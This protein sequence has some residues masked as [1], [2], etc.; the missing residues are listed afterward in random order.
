MLQDHG[1][2]TAN[3]VSMPFSKDADLLP[4]HENGA[5]LKTAE[6]KKYRSQTG[7]LL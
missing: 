5:L 4:V 7:C 2:E 3:S 6:H 1:I